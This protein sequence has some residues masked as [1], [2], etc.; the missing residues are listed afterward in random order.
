M[1]KEYSILISTFADKE[2]AKSI[3][4]LLVKR[5]L[6][7]CVQIFPIESVYLWKDEICEDNEIV[8]FIK[9]KSTLFDKI[10]ETIKENHSYEVPEIV[11]IPI[12]DGLSEYLQWID[13]S[14]A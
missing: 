11:Q 5:R 14:S 10:S 9:S 12:T 1:N 13:D 7:A 3:A 2:S 4:K 8:L 6:A